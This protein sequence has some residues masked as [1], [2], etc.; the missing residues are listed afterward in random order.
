MTSTS[1]AKWI[2]L[3]NLA[4]A[5]A[6]FIGATVTPEPAVPDAG[7]PSYIF[8]LFLVNGG[9]AVMHLLV[10]TIGL[11]WLY[12]HWPSRSYLMAHTAWYFLLSTIGL[13]LIPQLQAERQLWGIAL[14]LP[15]HLGHAAL[16]GLSLLALTA[17]KPAL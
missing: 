12:A 8:G 6:T 16:A 4:A 10:G 1:A 9:H 13:I 14:N 7:G 5:T 17:S 3:L 2:T 11:F 15:D